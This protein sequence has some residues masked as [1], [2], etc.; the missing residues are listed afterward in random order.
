MG[1]NDEW[2]D[3]V[4]AYVHGRW[5]FV[6]VLVLNLMRGEKNEG[7]SYPFHPVEMMYGKNLYL[8]VLD[9]ACVI[10]LIKKSLADA[11]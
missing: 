1:M 11:A 2:P 3:P 4:A 7:L 8:S 10:P 9:C 6:L 5:G